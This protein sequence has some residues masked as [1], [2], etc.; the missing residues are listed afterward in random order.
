MSAH[1]HRRQSSQ[2]QLVPHGG[3]GA[4]HLRRSSASTP[5]AWRTDTT[6]YDDGAGPDSA[7]HS[8]QDAGDRPQDPHHHRL[9]RQGQG[10]RPH[11]R[12]TKRWTQEVPVLA[13]KPLTVGTAIPG[14]TVMNTI[15]ATNAPS[16]AATPATN[17]AA[18][19][20][21]RPRRTSPAS[22]PDARL[23][24][25]PPRIR[26]T[27]GQRRARHPATHQVTCRSHPSTATSPPAIPSSPRSTRRCAGRS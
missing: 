20:Q 3:G 14:A 7:R 13:A 5:R 2:V 25:T 19:G 4:F 27:D 22:K 1:D 23:P 26:S 6:G 21:S 16:A 12:S 24:R 17:A 15:P 11:S 9:D 18:L 10:R 8:P